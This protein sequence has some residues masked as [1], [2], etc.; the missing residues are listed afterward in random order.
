MAKYPIVVVKEN[1]GTPDTGG[2]LTIEVKW[3]ESGME[4]VVELKFP[5]LVGTVRDEATLNGTQVRKANGKYALELGDV[6]IDIAD[7]EAAAP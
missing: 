2:K 3:Y 5:H 7:A 1:P 4:R 6:D